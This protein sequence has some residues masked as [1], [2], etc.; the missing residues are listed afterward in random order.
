MRRG[1]IENYNPVCY[2]KAG[3]IRNYNPACYRNVGKNPKIIIQL[4]IV[5]R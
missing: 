2:S 1:K 3:K 4:V 5:R